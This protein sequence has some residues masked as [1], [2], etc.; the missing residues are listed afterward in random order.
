MFEI[1]NCGQVPLLWVN[2]CILNYSS[3]S[4]AEFDRDMIKTQIS[5][6]G[7]RNVDH[8]VEIYDPGESSTLTKRTS[9]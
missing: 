2:M 9:K 4:C 5:I 6:L 7:L 1:V 3:V 8:Q